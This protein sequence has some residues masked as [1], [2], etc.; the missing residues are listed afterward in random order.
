MKILKLLNKRYFFVIFYLF[1]GLSSSAEDQPIDIWN[2]DKQELEKESNSENSLVTVEDSKKMGPDIYNMQSQKN[3]SVIK[4]DE[5]LDLKDIKIT[6]LYD[7][8]DFSLDINMWSNS[9][10]DQ[11]K[12]IFTKLNK[13]DL[14]KDAAELMN[15]SM[16]TNAYY[17][18]KNISEE[19]FLNIRSEWLIKNSDLKLIEEYLLKNQIMNSHPKLTKFLIDQHL[20]NAKTEQACEIFS[21]NKEPL[22]DE[23]LF[24]FKIYCL[25]KYNKREEAQLIFDLK[26]ELG[27]NNKYFEKKIYF[28]LGYTSEID[29]TLSEKNILDFHLAHQTN[30]DFIFE[31]KK[32]TDPSIWKYLASYN[33]LNSFKEIDISEIEKISTLEKAAHDKNY[34]EK[35]LFEL[36]KRFQFNINQLLNIVE[37]SK[38][39]SNIETRAL[40]YQRI[41]LESETTE[42]LKL[43][44]LL[45]NSFKKDNLNNAF[46]LELKEFLIEID[47]VNIPDNLT[48]FYY[49]NIELNNNE[50]KKIKFNK[51]VLHQSKLINYFNGDYAKSKIEKDIENYLK[52]IKK[53]KKYFFSKKDQIFLETLKADGIEISKKYNDLYEVNQSEIPNDIQVMINN[54]EKGAAL[55]RIIE[56]IGQDELEKIDEDT[57]YFIISTLNQLNINV[58]RNNIL[59]KVLP[60]KV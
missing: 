35:E 43:L 15:I 28:L 4:Q 26:K 45:K 53:D 40:I 8:E 60:L 33:L 44:K 47:P 50:L 14:S 49:T 51:D 52:K 22:N 20:I 13:I 24:K 1:V 27:F 11:L 42:K 30:P 37:S 32:T 17:P 16:L 12:N 41:L 19:E 23:Y 6:G 25:I 21:K 46:D 56:V 31:P 38:L 55:L 58:I 9:D 7:P 3:S 39:L 5:I 57:I 2:I 29:K 36:Y 10:G 34:P 59:L 18:K 54:N 48:S